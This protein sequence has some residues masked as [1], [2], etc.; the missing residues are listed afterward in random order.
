MDKTPTIAQVIGLTKPKTGVYGIEVE[1]ESKTGRMA[2]LDVPVKGWTRVPEGSVRNGLEY[3]SRKPKTKEQRKK[4]LELLYKHLKSAP[5]D[6]ESHR[7]SIH[8]HINVSDMTMLGL[9]KYMTAYFLLEN[10][11]LS[12]S[13]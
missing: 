2:R 8:V 5:V 13:P 11:I 1:V 9:L 12:Y 4:D 7:T 6:W 10:L 3:I